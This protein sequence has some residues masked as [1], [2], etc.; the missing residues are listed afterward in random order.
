MSVEECDE[1]SSLDDGCSKGEWG[2]GAEQ[3]GW[4]GLMG[5]GV[6]WLH[7]LEQGMLQHLVLRIR[8]AR[9]PQSPFVLVLAR[10]ASLFSRYQRI[11]CLSL[12]LIQNA[13]QATREL[14]SLTFLRCKSL[15]S[16]FGAA[17]TRTNG[18]NWAASPPRRDLRQP[19]RTMDSRLTKRSRMPKYCDL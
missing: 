2:R 19:R 10:L 6:N 4:S 9:R 17:S 15:S 11:S 18:E 1:S 16:N 13:E 12:T 7:R 14:Y 8:T 3:W 5:K